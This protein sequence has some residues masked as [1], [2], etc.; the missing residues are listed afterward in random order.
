MEQ[1]EA[2]P[3]LELLAQIHNRLVDLTKLIA[4]IE[5]SKTQSEALKQTLRQ[6]LT[7]AKPVEVA[8][9]PGTVTMRQQRVI[10]PTDGDIT[11]GEGRDLGGT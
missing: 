5:M 8:T 1:S 3:E 9:H 6:A 7:T 2:N 11:P 4:E 10:A